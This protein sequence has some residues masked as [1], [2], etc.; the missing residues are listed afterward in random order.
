MNSIRPLDSWLH[1][2]TVDAYAQNQAEISLR[3]RGRFLLGSILT[4][5]AGLAAMATAADLAATA[6]R[7]AA[8]LIAVATAI[9]SALAFHLDYN[10][11]AVDHHVTAR[12]LQA[13]RRAIEEVESSSLPAPI[14]HDRITEIRRL[15]DATS[16]RSPNVPWRLVERGRERAFSTVHQPSPGWRGSWGL[17]SGGL[18]LAW[19]VRARSP[20]ARDQAGVCARPQV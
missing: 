5:T 18:L 7:L 20:R 2:V 4:L 12:Q 15:W 6:W 14:E 10:A 17:L 8:V 9:L 1:R 3:R 19:L 11:R 16:S 13:I